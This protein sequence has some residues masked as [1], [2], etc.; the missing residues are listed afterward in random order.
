M[1]IR[2]KYERLR[3]YDLQFGFV[4]NPLNWQLESSAYGHGVRKL[5][6]GP[7]SVLLIYSA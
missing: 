4:L 3:W 2:E 6:L 1:S 5:C 7:F